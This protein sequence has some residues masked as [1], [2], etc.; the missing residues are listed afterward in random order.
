MWPTQQSF[1]VIIVR[2]FLYN[3]IKFD[4]K[5]TKFARIYRYYSAIMS[6]WLARN[7]ERAER[8]KSAARLRHADG[9]ESI[10]ITI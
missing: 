5:V 7:A 6:P 8:A 9:T 3:L 4:C 10:G 1:E 2:V